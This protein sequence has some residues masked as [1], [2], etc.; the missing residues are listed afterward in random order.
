MGL[1]KEKCLR[2]GIHGENVIL[3]ND[4]TINI[5][6]FKGAIKQNLSF[7]ESEG[8]INNLNIMNNSMIIWTQ[9]HYLR[10]FDLSRREYK[11]VGVTRKF[12]DST[13]SLG[14]IRSCAINSDG[15]KV[16]IVAD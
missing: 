16:V 13:G 12:E 11:Q 5:A 4:F 10:V 7:P 2:A 9:E 3:G 15:S 14:L 1:F 6:N 8:K